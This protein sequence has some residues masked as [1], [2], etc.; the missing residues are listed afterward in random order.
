MIIQFLGDVRNLPFSLEHRP[1]YSR[2]ARYSDG[3]RIWLPLEERSGGRKQNNL[4]YSGNDPDVVALVSNIL[5]E[6]SHQRTTS[7]WDTPTK[8]FSPIWYIDL[9]YCSRYSSLFPLNIWECQN[10]T[11]LLETYRTYEEIAKEFSMELLGRKFNDLS[12]HRPPCFLPSPELLKLFNLQNKD[13]TRRDLNPPSNIVPECSNIKK[14][15]DV[16]TNGD[17]SASQILAARYGEQEEGIA[18]EALGASD[19]K[20]SVLPSLSARS[21]RMWYLVTEQNKLCAKTGAY[22]AA[23][24]VSLVPPQLLQKNSIPETMS[25]EQRVDCDNPTAFNIKNKHSVYPLQDSSNLIPPPPGFPKKYSSYSGDKGL[26]VRS[27][28]PSKGLCATLGSQ[29]ALQK[30]G[31][32]QNDRLSS[33]KGNVKPLHSFRGRWV[34][35]Q[36]PRPEC[37]G[38]ISRNPSPCGGRYR[39]PANRFAK[40]QRLNSARNGEYA[41]RKKKPTG[42]R[43]RTK[44]AYVGPDWTK[45]DVLRWKKEMDQRKIQD[46]PA[47]PPPRVSPSGPS[48]LVG[49]GNI[50]HLGRFTQRDASALY[51]TLSSQCSHN[52]LVNS[53]DRPNYM[54]RMRLEG[55]YKHWSSL[56]KQRIKL[57]ADL[58]KSFHWTS[59]AT[60]EIPVFQLPDKPSRMDRLIWIQ[61]QEQAK[62][63]TLLE[64]I[65]HTFNITI[66]SNVW[67]VLRW[68]LAAIHKTQ[69]RRNIQIFKVGNPSTREKIHLAFTNDIMSLTS[70]LTKLMYSTLKTR[71]ALFRV[72]RSII[73]I[74]YWT[75]VPDQ[76]ASYLANTYQ[77]ARARR[78]QI[79]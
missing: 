1:L 33:S 56:R 12:L 3:S 73:D 28:N 54:F 40:C 16:V 63:F 71:R 58:A 2:V 65:E 48:F 44:L 72:V 76:K 50:P 18:R 43:P 78:K 4:L 39:P 21:E 10:P 49:Y 70:A 6:S 13:F 17:S 66:H 37:V 29:T 36:A 22:G 27:F 64:K 26:S 74:K 30:R 51:H 15:G 45:P 77:V 57:E 14:E 31:P 62:A 7:E 11:N 47:F 23:R 55:C 60:Y 9:E 25:I 69:A 53:R 59:F 34:D 68:H 5:Q 8:T 79:K 38:E 20:K 52:S 24:L 46:F 75:R 67:K 42:R 32:L 41:G 35:A 19:V 61:F